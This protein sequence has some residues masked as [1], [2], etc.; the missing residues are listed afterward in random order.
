LDKLKRVIFKP[1]ELAIPV[2][3]VIEVLIRFL[4]ELY[5]RSDFHLAPAAS[6]YSRKRFICGPA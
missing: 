2:M 5:L 1:A 4:D 3:A 6:K